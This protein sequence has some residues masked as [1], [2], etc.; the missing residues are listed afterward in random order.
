MIDISKSD[1]ELEK[2]EIRNSAYNEGFSVGYDEG[3]LDGKASLFVGEGSTLN[4]QMCDVLLTLYESVKTS[5]TF[6]RIL[7][8]EFE[9]V[10]GV[11]IQ[12]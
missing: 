6:L 2:I 5:P 11:K 4:A 7:F 1:E 9:D 8:T 10:F 12:R 3:Y